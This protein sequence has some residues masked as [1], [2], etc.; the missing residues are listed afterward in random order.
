M[1]SERT[2]SAVLGVTLLSFFIVVFFYGGSQVLGAFKYPIVTMFAGFLSG[3]VGYYIT[4]A[5]A[6]DASWKLP[7]GGTLNVKGTGGF[8]FALVGIAIFIYFSPLQSKD[9]ATQSLLS[10]FKTAA[11]V[12]SGDQSAGGQTAIAPDTQRLALQVA[13]ATPGG[14]EQIVN[15]V[16]QPNA[17]AQQLG[18]AIATLQGSARGNTQALEQDFGNGIGQFHLGADVD[19]IEKLAGAP[20]A[21]F[22]QLVLAP[23][24]HTAEV[25]YFW[26]YLGDLYNSSAGKQMIDYLQFPK[27]CRDAHQGYVT[28][29]FQANQLMRVSVRTSPSCT[30]GKQYFVAWAHSYWL[31]VDPNSTVLFQQRLS[32]TTIGAYMT[33]DQV[34]MLDVYGNTSPSPAA[35]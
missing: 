25:R 19:S 8:A 34:I 5:I 10:R 2:V 7:G 22:P 14:N 11:L 9:Q 24:Y 32:K 29:L 21:T 12:K 23:E 33:D 18:A 27:A 35:L 15:A 17:T 6:T 13:A 20:E 31:D 26:L 3:L 4:G 28:F 1:A 30:T 16:A